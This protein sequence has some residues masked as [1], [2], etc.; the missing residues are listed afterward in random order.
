[1]LENQNILDK[2]FVMSKK[3]QGPLKYEIYD[4]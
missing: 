4:F 3:A 2:I 1:M